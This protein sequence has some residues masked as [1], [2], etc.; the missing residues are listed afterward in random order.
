MSSGHG[1]ME[2]IRIEGKQDGICVCNSNVQEP[3]VEIE[4]V[5]RKARAGCGGDRPWLELLCLGTMSPMI[6]DMQ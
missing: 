1:L 2:E 3:V 5:P 6:V 4:P